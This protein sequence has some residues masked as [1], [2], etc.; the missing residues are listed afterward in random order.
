MVSIRA[1]V[2]A[3]L[4]ATMAWERVGAAHLGL[5]RR[6]DASPTTTTDAIETTTGT[7]SGDRTTTATGTLETGK[8]S[9]SSTQSDDITS[10]IMTSI[11]ATAI[12]SAINGNNANGSDSIFVNSTIPEG[13]LPL[14]PQLTP[15][16]GVSGAL[17]L[18][19]GA[20]YTLIG[21]KNAWLHTFFSTA[22]LSSL[23]VAVLII[24]VMIPPVPNAIQGAYVVA[25]TCTGLILGGAA[26]VFRE[27]TEGLGCLLGGFCI[28]MWLLTLHEGGL[29]PETPG[30]VIL[31][32][33][34]TIFCYGLYFSRYTRPYALIG[35]MA[36][37]GATVTVLGIDCFSRAGLKEFWVYIWD[38][39]DNL[40]P[41]GV[42]TYPLTKGIR[43]EI[44]ITII[45]TI[46]GVI[47]QLKLW[48]VI[49]E[50]RDRRAEKR[51]EA[52]Q[53]RDQEEEEIGRQIEADN[54]RE[55]RQWETVYGN[56]PPASLSGSGDSGVGDLDNEK[57]NRHSRTTVKR[58]TS[59]G[60]EIEMDEFPGPLADSSPESQRQMEEDQYEGEKV[61]IGAIDEEGKTLKPMAEPDEKAWMASADGEA[62]RV[63]GISAR[64]SQ[65]FSKVSGPEVTPLPFK[66]PS[67]YEGEGDHDGDRSS[68]ATFA[69]EDERSVYMNKRASRG[70]LGNRLSV[71]STHIL[72]SISRN[73]LRSEKSNRRS[74][75]FESAQGSPRFGE[76]FENLVAKDR[77]PSNAGSMAATVD[78]MSMDGNDK[79]QG[80]SEWTKEIMAELGDKT[81][82]PPSPNIEIHPPT[83]AKSPT[84]GAFLNIRPLSTAE[85]IG[86]DNFNA[87]ELASKRSSTTNGANK[88]EPVNELVNTETAATSGLGS[89][90]PAR[91]EK[92]AAPSVTS[93]SNASLTKDRL[94]S[95]LSRVALSYRTNEWAK[96]L[97]LADAPEADQLQL[98][99]RLEEVETAKQ[100]PEASVPVDVDSLQQTA[101]NSIPATTIKRSPSSTS[102]APAMPTAVY[103]S[104]SRTSLNSSSNIRL[105]SI[106]IPALDSSGPSNRPSPVK[107]G[108]PRPLQTRDSFRSKG[109]RHSSDVNIQPIL[110]EH[111]NERFSTIHSTP[112]EGSRNSGGDSHST[113]PARDQL[114]NHAP[115]PGIVSHNAPQTL[116]GKRDMYLRNKSALSL[117]S[118]PI[119]E[120]NQPLVRSSGQI[121][122][123]Q[124]ASPYAT[125]DADEMPLSQRKN[126]LRQSSVLSRSSSGPLRLSSTMNRA[127]P[128]P[129]PGQLRL[130]VTEG[131]YDAR[132]PQRGSTLPSQAAREAQLASFRQSVAAEL[133]A[134]TPVT[135][136]ANA[137]RE[138]P[139]L[140]A[141][142]ASLIGTTHGNNDVR[143][144]IDQQRNM[145]L[146]QR[147]QLAQRRE[148]ERW[149][150]ERN[151]RAFEEM[152]RRGDLMDA[153]R[154][155]L[156]RMQGRVE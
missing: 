94:P 96:H 109:R 69:D 116:L 117:Y 123:Y 99:Q 3:L 68:F 124:M 87:S 112:S 127:S 14:Q 37:S 106:T 115:V 64:S 108:V 11:S 136:A 21:I 139:M 39:N 55:R 42:D 122:P 25:A 29:V 15:G 154:D 67:L 153:H 74:G 41:L 105:S 6:Q 71:G 49:K 16:W 56:E 107:E 34:F 38:L 143:K 100:E 32:A 1:G 151:E 13:E 44:A 125:E 48:R 7:G 89:T 54:A 79:S 90:K 78:D 59:D 66:I 146:S 10:S 144:T 18:I 2:S 133:R 77:R 148:I 17:L 86:T 33:V 142:M 52:Q 147:E 57:K 4:Y 51:A 129:A 80:H 72:R 104:G 150:K 156:R 134:G 65:R 30:K 137:G 132:Q 102:N 84:Y 120:N 140:N 58:L 75:L 93:H 81:S 47:S 88:T 46:V 138:T 63:S 83:D 36:F 141:S 31:I 60:E 130:N 128:S 9:A 111:A 27:L 101:H 135:P 12:P 95:A 85:S 92:S 28:A 118:P 20:V 61:T 121:D 126:L 97:S 149:E 73:S 70:S 5:Y 8:A 35:L 19:T 145:M 62:K 76:S 50:N 114:A 98:N 53:K 45:L 152:M 91:S 155:A 82:N 40:F 26:V 103:R 23:S 22:Y 24:Y 131:N 119:S 110:E 43:V 113:S